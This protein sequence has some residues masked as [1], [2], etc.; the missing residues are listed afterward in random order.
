LPG[1]L[2]EVDVPAMARAVGPHGD[3]HVVRACIVVETARTVWE[4]L[5]GGFEGKVG[6]MAFEGNVELMA[7]AAH[8]VQ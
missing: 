3:A 8:S 5:R 1:L 7:A 4:R 2:A 6:P